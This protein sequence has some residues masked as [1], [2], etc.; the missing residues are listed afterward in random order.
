MDLIRVSRKRRKK[1]LIRITVMAFL[2][3]FF[4]SA[5]LL[6]HSQMEE[7]EHQRNMH[8]YGKWILCRQS[9]VTPEDNLHP[10]VEKLGTVE[11]GVHVYYEAEGDA[12]EN[13]TGLNIGAFPDNMDDVGD[14]GIY[15]G[16]LP[17]NGDEIAI[18]LGALERLGLSYELGQQIT[19]N[20]GRYYDIN[21][22]YENDMLQEYYTRTYTLVGTLYNYTDVWC[23]NAAMPSLVVTKEEYDSFEAQKM[24]IAFYGLRKEYQ[25][26]DTDFAEILAK[27]DNDMSYNSRVYDAVVW[28]DRGMN[29]WILVLILLVGGCSMTY[30]ISQEQKKRK[31]HYYLMRCLG[32]GK[33]QVRGFSASESM[34]TALP[35]SLAGI[36]SAYV[37]C[38][39][40]I[41]PV[42]YINGFDWFFKFDFVVLLEIVAAVLLT[43]FAALA[44]SQC[45]LM[46][47][48][49]AAGGENYGKHVAERARKG[50]TKGRL[51]TPAFTAH[52]RNKL[53]PFKNLALRVLGI[54]MCT[55]V[56]LGISKITY[57]FYMYS[58]ATESGDDFMIEIPSGYGYRVEY[59]LDEAVTA[60][61]DAYFDTM[62]DGLPDAAVKSMEIIPGIKNISY[63]AQDSSHKLSWEGMEESE[64]FKS[65]LDE[66]TL[67]SSMQKDGITYEVRWQYDDIYGE[68]F[69]YTFYAKP[70]DI[71]KQC[72]SYIDWEGADYNSFVEGEQVILVCR[73]LSG[74]QPEVKPGTVLTIETK[75]G[76]IKV[77]VAAVMSSMEF[78]GINKRYQ[79]VASQNLGEKIA[80][81]DGESLTYTKA[82]IT[83]D[84]YKD[85]EYIA[86]QLSIIAVRN[87]GEYRSFYKTY[88]Y[89]YDEAMHNLILY[90][91]FI[92]AVLIMTAIVRIGILKDGLQTQQ[93][94]WDRQR[95]IGMPG[96]YVKRVAVNQALRE[97]A[98]YFISIPIVML[99]NVI[100]R[101]HEVKSGGFG[102]VGAY[103][104]R[105]GGSYVEYTPSGNGKYV[106]FGVLD[107][108][109]ELYLIFLVLFVAGFVIIS[110]YLSGK[111]VKGAKEL[112]DKNEW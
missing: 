91:S 53:H 21:K 4:S 93:A 108:D 37:L 109:Y 28:G 92:L 26:I 97:G 9:W 29:T 111:L 23:V 84:G 19:V 27:D 24:H 14:I 94:A 5:V 30:V 61:L 106:L 34:M 39:L 104:F 71:W 74:Q 35:A 12:R 65:H 88:K 44:V 11:G 99:V 79:V 72:E 81:S 57:G 17:Q 1:Q 62:Y 58:V 100:K 25:D 68:L 40:I 70:G 10:Y 86:K 36:I 52:R 54:A 66:A 112:E 32:A 6:Y 110:A 43:L 42:S 59:K 95:Q 98:A 45:T 3:S 31:K 64:E 75:Q 13:D 77:T 102:D 101:Y 76:D 89:L 69:G 55:I 105:R 60:C 46:G 33:A 83:F 50:A 18:A 56:L 82:V 63:T 41:L 7:Y 2:V 103:Y 85:A 67:D 87:G 38:M 22:L 16:R 15:E 80:A 48:R 90:G 8:L 20:Y 49:L 73:T 51:L 47:S 78:G 107:L 96:N